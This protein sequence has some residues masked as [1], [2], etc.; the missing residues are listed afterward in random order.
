M[1]CAEADLYS[2][3]NK[4]SF[5]EFAKEETDTGDEYIERII[6]A[7]KAASAEIDGYLAKQYKLP[8]A[9]T[10]PAIKNVAVDITIYKVLCRRGIEKDSPESIW[11]DR[12]K[13]A[14]KFLEGVRDGKNDIGIVT[15]ENT[16][17]PSGYAYVTETRIFDEKF[18]N[19]Y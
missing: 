17:T 19:G 4:A 9:I 6:E 16:S 3:I 8:L 10:P 15:A 2:Q 1:Y 13:S 14:I 11:F 5:I 12:Y 18:W 7:I